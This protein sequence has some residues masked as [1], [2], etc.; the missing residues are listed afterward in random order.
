MKSS[1][2]DTEMSRCFFTAFSHR[3]HCGEIPL[4]LGT[5]RLAPLPRC[6]CTP[7][8]R[9]GTALWSPA[10]HHRRWREAHR[11]RCNH[12]SWVRRSGRFGSVP[13]F[14]GLREGCRRSPARSLT[15]RWGLGRTSESPR[16]VPPDSAGRPRTVGHDC[17]NGTAPCGHRRTRSRRDA[18]WCH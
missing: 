16:A 14:C 3:R 9:W 4:R 8:E 11:R 15:F 5:G 10:Y 6:C 2:A 12:Y 18:L 7:P 17:P 13:R 1:Q